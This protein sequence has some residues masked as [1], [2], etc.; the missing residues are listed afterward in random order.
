MLQTSVRSV[1]NQ[2][3]EYTVW[4]SGLLSV[5]VK[6]YMEKTHGETHSGYTLELLNVF[7]LQREGES[8][9]FKPVCIP[10][11]IFLPDLDFMVLSEITSKVQVN[12]ALDGWRFR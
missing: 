11:W 9:R 3:S 1:D 5:Q 12:L 6:Q 7:K 4:Y 10:P 2:N 8:E